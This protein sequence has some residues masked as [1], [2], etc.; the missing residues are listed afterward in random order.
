MKNKRWK[1][2]AKRMNGNCL[3][4]ELCSIGTLKICPHYDRC[5]EITICEPCNLQ[6]RELE[7]RCKGG[8]NDKY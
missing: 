4:G 7:R 2:E 5:R 1:R 3:K 6:I 8:K